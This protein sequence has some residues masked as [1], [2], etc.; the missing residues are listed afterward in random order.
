MRGV[1]RGIFSALLDDPDFQSLSPKARHVFLT[2]RLCAQA[3]P[4]CIFRFYAA[5][6]R[7]QTGLETE[8]IEKALVELQAGRWIL[9]EG[10]VLW[11]RNALRH[12]PFVRLADPKHRKAVERWIAG[13]PKVGLVVSFCD[14]YQI[15]RPFDDPSETLG[16]PSEEVS[17]RNTESRI[18]REEEAVGGGGRKSAEKEGGGTYR[19][20][21]GRKPH[22]GTYGEIVDRLRR[23][24]PDRPASELE[25]TALEELHRR[26]GA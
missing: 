25:A 19:S 1:Y 6:L 16:R 7:E 11:L 12:D 24:H 14:Y 9:R 18:P 20:D 13:L 10:P 3:G 5:V 8:E 21:N 22:L 26:M 2:L 15:E 23:L 17:H 4:A